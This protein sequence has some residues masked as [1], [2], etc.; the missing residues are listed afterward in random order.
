MNLYSVAP[1]SRIK[2]YPVVIAAYSKTHKRLE[3]AMPIEFLHEEFSKEFVELDTIEVKKRNPR[4]LKKTY[5]KKKERF[6][7]SPYE[8]QLAK[9]SKVVIQREKDS[10]SVYEL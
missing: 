3:D 9:Q 8:R 6:G 7:K 10:Y 5:R 1:L 2:F 4:R